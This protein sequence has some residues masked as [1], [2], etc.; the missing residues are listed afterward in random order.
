[1]LSFGHNDDASG[2]V[3][4]V[5][6]HAEA[7]ARG[8]RWV[9]VEP[10]LSVTGATASQWVPIRP[11]TDAA[12]LFAMLHVL[13]H[14]MSW[15]DVCDRPF[16]ERLTNA[17]YLV[18]PHGY[19]LRDPTSLKPLVWDTQHGRAVPFD[20]PGITAYTLEGSHAVI[21]S[22]EV[23]P[24]AQHWTHCAALAALALLVSQGFLLLR[25]RG[26]PAWNQWRV[27]VLFVVSGFLM[28]AAGGSKTVW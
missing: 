23:G 16:L 15:Q 8:L 4:G 7:R 6:R 19:Y 13:L 27:P 22:V 2:G 17:P 28:G 21:R 10:H 25:A 12:V 26:I 9:Q 5:W 1:V 3:T 18:G 11:K 24:D 20:F 14:E